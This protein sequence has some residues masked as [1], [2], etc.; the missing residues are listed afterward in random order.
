[1]EKEIDTSIETNSQQTQAN[2]K[3]LQEV[4]GVQKLNEMAPTEFYKL[5]KHHTTGN[6]I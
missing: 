5:Y 2:I 4:Y 1:L 6:N 3:R